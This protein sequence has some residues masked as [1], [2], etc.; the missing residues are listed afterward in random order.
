MSSIAQTPDKHQFK[1]KYGSV[2]LERNGRI[3]VASFVGAI[4]AGVLKYFSEHLELLLGE[5]KGRP[6]CYLN[7]S[8]EAMVGTEEAEA[9]LIESGRLGHKWGCVQAAYVLTSP[10]AIAQTKRIRENIGIEQPL[11]DVLFS[12]EDDAFQYLTAFLDQLPESS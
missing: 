12:N 2:S 11:S 10:V 9:V 6:W 4:N 7:N 8:P 5:L 1:N 3:I